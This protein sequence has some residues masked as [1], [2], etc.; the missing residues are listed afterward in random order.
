MFQALESQIISIRHGQTKYTNIFPDL[1]EEGME[2]IRKT[3]EQLKP[4]IQRFGRNIRILSSPAPRA[5]GSASI[6]A[7]ENGLEDIAI[8][9]DQELRPFDIK[10]PGYFEYDKKNS[11]NIY[12]EM[13]V[14]DP[15]LQGENLF[16]EGRT[17]VE[18]RAHQALRRIATEVLAQSET[19]GN[20]ILALAFSHFEVNLPFLHAHYPDHENFPIR[21]GIKPPQPAEAIIIHLP[22]RTLRRITIEARG[23]KVDVEQDIA[24]RRFRRLNNS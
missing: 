9:I 8:E 24:N 22:D 6:V 15:L 23:Q 2:N 18:A 20:P 19:E 11:T 16:I 1:T 3:A 14:H 13:W 5:L 7:Q 4:I 10:N 17:S 12:G 21:E